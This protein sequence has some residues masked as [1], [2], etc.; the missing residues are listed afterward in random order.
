M[1]SDVLDELLYADVR[2]DKNQLRGKI[3]SAMDKFSQS[4]DNYDL[5]ISTKKR[6]YTNQHLHLVNRT[7]NQ[8]S[9]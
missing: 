5:T 2:Y 1:Q 8:P 3:Q 7:M 6:L 4:C 9:L